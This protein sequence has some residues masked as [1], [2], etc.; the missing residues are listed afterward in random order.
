VADPAVLP[1]EKPKFFVLCD[2]CHF[3]LNVLLM[4]AV[5]TKQQNRKLFHYRCGNQSNV[6]ESKISTIVLL[7]QIMPTVLNV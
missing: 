4:H 2:I 7:Q 3:I 5:N 6:S 1:I